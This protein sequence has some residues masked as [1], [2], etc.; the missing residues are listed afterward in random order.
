MLYSWSCRAILLQISSC[1]RLPVFS[2]RFCNSLLGLANT[3]LQKLF[4]LS[5]LFCSIFTN[6]RVESLQTHLT[7]LLWN[8]ERLF[9]N[10]FIAGILFWIA[11]SGTALWNVCKCTVYDLCGIL[12]NAVS[13]AVSWKMRLCDANTGPHKAEDSMLQENR[14]GVGAGIRKSADRQWNSW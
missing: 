1:S 13:T 4:S 6:K 2:V 12:D 8:Q 9:C 5:L 11:G 3:R 10:G 14:T 7:G